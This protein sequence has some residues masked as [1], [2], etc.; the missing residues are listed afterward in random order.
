MKRSPKRQAGWRPFPAVGI[1]VIGLV[2]SMAAC[3]VHQI[4]TAS[5]YNGPNYPTSL[6]PGDVAFVALAARSSNVSDQFAA[7]LLKPVGRGTRITFSAGNWGGSA[8]ISNES[9]FTWTADQGYPAGS[10]LEIFD[11]DPFPVTLF[12][13][14]NAY[15]QSSNLSSLSGTTFGLSKNGDNLFAYQGTRGNPV[16]LAG[17]IFGGNGQSLT[18]GGTDDSARI[19]AL[20]SSLVNGTTAN[21]LGGTYSF[22]YYDCTYLSTGTAAALDAAMNNPVHWTAKQDSSNQDLNQSGD[23]LICGIAPQ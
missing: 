20:P 15:D 21:S 1:L 11:N 7:V 14:G 2:V 16:F 17:L 6:G 10:V 3:S 19:E 23:V 5:G 18:W 13:D 8:F 9:Y 22:G 4:P 12:A